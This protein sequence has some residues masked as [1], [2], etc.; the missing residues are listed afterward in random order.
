MD[1]IMIHLDKDTE[2]SLRSL[3]PVP[4]QTHDVEFAV[5]WLLLVGVGTV[6]TALEK[7][8]QL[9][10]GDLISLSFKIYNG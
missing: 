3:F 6:K 7:N 4:M 10:L 5:D 9:T 8:P 1:G 2:N